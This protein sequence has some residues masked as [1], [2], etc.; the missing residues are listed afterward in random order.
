MP[1]APG[2]GTAD[3]RLRVVRHIDDPWW[4]P[5]HAVRRG[6]GAAHGDD[7]RVMVELLV[8]ADCPNQGSAAGLVRGVLDGLGMDEMPVPVRVVHSRVE[9]EQCGFSGSPTILIDGI[10]PFAEPGAQPALACRLYATSTG[11]TGLPDEAALRAAIRAAVHR[12]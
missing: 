9:A 10:D 12:Q 6:G 7:D 8:V 1:D 2:G 3:R 4:R 11:L 5:A